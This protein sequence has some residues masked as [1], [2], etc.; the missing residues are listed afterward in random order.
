MARW[1]VVYSSTSCIKAIAA[2]SN[3]TFSMHR[4]IAAAPSRYFLFLSH[5]VQSVTYATGFAASTSAP[6]LDE[7][8][9][10]KFN[11]DATDAQSLIKS[12]S[13]DGF[14]SSKAGW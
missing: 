1:N 14:L 13:S 4:H 12:G 7:L 6:L 3:G 8:S 11:S 2:F 9:F 10:F 5:N